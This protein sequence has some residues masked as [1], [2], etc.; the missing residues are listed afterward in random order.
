[1]PRRPARIGGRGQVAAAQIRHNIGVLVTA[2]EF[3]H[4]TTVF[5]ATEFL[6]AADNLAR[7]DGRRLPAA[8]HAL[9]QIRVVINAAV[10]LGA[11][12]GAP[13]TGERI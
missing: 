1:M 7:N 12:H 3:D 6:D 2:L 13:L 9:R 4:P 10:D 5:P 8:L 11:E